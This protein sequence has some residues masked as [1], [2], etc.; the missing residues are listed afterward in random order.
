MAATIISRGFRQIS[1]HGC[2]SNKFY[3][4]TGHLRCSEKGISTA[5]QTQGMNSA[6]TRV[7]CGVFSH[8]F[9]LSFFFFFW[10]GWSRMCLMFASP[11]A[12]LPVTAATGLFCRRGKIESRLLR[13]CQSHATPLSGMAKCDL[14]KFKQ[15]AV[16][17]C[18]LVKIVRPRQCVQ[19]S[20]TL[21]SPYNWNQVMTE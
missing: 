11:D 9:C 5:Q 1:F 17:F 20:R 21:I 18:L 19:L 15:P 16:T 13:F 4:T 2:M 3:V 6:T 7:S 14:A 12:L 10:L 8:F